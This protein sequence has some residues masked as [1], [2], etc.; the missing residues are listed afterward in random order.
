MIIY[1]ASDII[2]R[3]DQKSDVALLVD[4]LRKKI[5][6]GPS[7]ESAVNDANLK[8]ADDSAEVRNLES[9]FE[10][11]AVLWMSTDRSPSADNNRS[12]WSY[13]STSSD[14]GPP[15]PRFQQ[16]RYDD[17]FGAPEQVN[18]DNLQSYCPGREDKIWATGSSAVHDWLNQGIEIGSKGYQPWLVQRKCSLDNHVS[19]SLFKEVTAKKMD[20]K[21]GHAYSHQLP[22]VPDVMI[23][24]ENLLTSPK[25]HFQP[26]KNDSWQREVSIIIDSSRKGLVPCS[27]QCPNRITSRS[28]SRENRLIQPPRPSSVSSKELA[29]FIDPGCDVEEHEEFAESVVIVEDVQDVEDDPVNVELSVVEVDETD[30][31]EYQA[32]ES[33]LN[34]VLNNRPVDGYEEECSVQIESC[35]LDQVNDTYTNM[36][37]NEELLQDL[38]N[39]ITTAETVYLTDDSDDYFLHPASD[40]DS[41]LDFH[42][43]PALLFVYNRSGKF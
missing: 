19:T 34:E 38:N 22:N 25:T 7:V 14:S 11:L 33:I 32:I 21:I 9:K 36:P 10:Q 18:E 16:Q 28:N 8:N 15:S 37:W 1:S 6:F 27:T 13:E 30:E 29:S 23:F 17:L 5:V 4:Q 40:V 43:D 2:Y 12:I 31:S 26:I 41:S 39:Q 35:E 24:D 42:N 3:Q 20:G